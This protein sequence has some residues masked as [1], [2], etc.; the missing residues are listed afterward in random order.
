MA[1]ELNNYANDYR[2]RYRIQSSP[3]TGTPT[4][5]WKG[6]AASNYNVIGLPAE[7][8]YNMYSSGSGTVCS[9]FAERHLENGTP[10]NVTSYYT[11]G[12]GNG[13]GPIDGRYS[14]DFV[15]DPGSSAGFNIPRSATPPASPSEGNLWFDTVNLALMIYFND[16]NSTQWVAAS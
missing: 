14:L 2:V 12:P 13:L 5:K 4:V 7:S 8:S 16:G 15:D 10:T 3:A 9:P 11:H 1:T 6:G